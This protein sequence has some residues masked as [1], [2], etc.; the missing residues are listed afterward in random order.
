MNYRILYHPEIQRDIAGL[1]RNM[2][3]RIRKAIEQRL[4]ADPLRFG[5][6]LRRSLHGYRKLRAGDY[7]IIFKID[8][9]NIV[10]LKIGH[11]KEVYRGMDQRKP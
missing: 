1:P 5:T 4:L 7:R 9:E 2:K 10:V 11:R 8:N 3:D 6:P